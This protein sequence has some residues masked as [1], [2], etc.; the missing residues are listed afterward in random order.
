M[1]VWSGLYCSTLLLKGPDVY[2]PL[3]PALPQTL[4][5]ARVTICYLLNFHCRADMR[6]EAQFVLQIEEEEEDE[7]EN[8]SYKQAQG[9]FLKSHQ[10]AQQY[11]KEITVITS[12]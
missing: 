10:N 4:D 12:Q 2:I 9:L 3:T 8:T 11:A 1:L 5:L 6:Q 7:E